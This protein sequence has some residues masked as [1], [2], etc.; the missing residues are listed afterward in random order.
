MMRT[1]LENATSR[2]AATSASPASPDTEAYGDQPTT[3]SVNNVPRSTES[4]PTSASSANN[5][6]SLRDALIGFSHSYRDHLAERPLA[7]RRPSNSEDLR[8]GRCELFVRD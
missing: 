6:T 7:R 2:R 1:M 5:I 4:L 3:S 8:L